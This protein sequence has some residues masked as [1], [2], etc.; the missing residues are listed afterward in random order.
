MNSLP[1]NPDV[2]VI[3]AGTSGL[4]AAREL[5]MA[6]IDTLVLESSDHVGGRCFTD[7]TTFNTPFDRGGSW[8]HSAEI[9]PLSKVA[10][11]NG[12][13]FH[14]KPWTWK[15]VTIDGYAL[16]DAE[17]AEYSDYMELMWE[18]IVEVGKKDNS[19]E[20]AS[21]LPDSR[22]RDTAKMFVAQMLGGDCDVTSPTD[23]ANYS[24]ADGDWLVGGGLGAFIKHLHSDVNV[25]LNCPVSKIDYSGP[26]IRVT[27][28]KGV[29]EAEHVILTVSVGVLAAEKI[30]FVPALPNWK[31]EAVNSLPNGL[32]NKVGIEF[33]HNWKE[34][35]EAFALDYHPSGEDFCSI[36]FRFYDSEL[37]TGFTAGRFAA[38]LEADGPGTA[39]DFCMEALRATFGNDVTKHVLKTSET[40]WNGNIH[41]FGSYSYVK[42]G[43]VDARKVLAETI[44]EKVFFAGEATMSN[45]FATVH[46]A[47]L[48]G[49]DAATR[50]LEVSGRTAQNSTIIRE[51]SR[52][53]Q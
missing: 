14:K 47:Y 40:H 43:C 24:D 8:L 38:Q 15:W 5:K 17:V 42:P 16:N 25:V 13:E 32:L 23:M 4:S 19:V 39:T 48:S 27:T 30:E 36:A 46:G 3:G 26:R 12:F 44:D 51:K 21:I 9:N 45:A 10:E 11:A 41:T 50:L 28:P 49:K 2:I 1:Q 53:Y 52:E 22:W 6:G 29:V 18:R 33:D 37:A 31:L 34:A 7:T 35:E 20:I